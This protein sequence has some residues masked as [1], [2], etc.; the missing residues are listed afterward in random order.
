M[1]R[2]TKEGMTS[3]EV[4]IPEIAKLR[5]DELARERTPPKGRKVF[6]SDI[7]RQALTEY[8]SKIGESVDFNV[9]RG[10][11]RRQQD[12]PTDG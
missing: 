7:V 3:I 6:A 11:D 2:I 1:A 9:D 5:L 4:V 8:F 12:D 10:G